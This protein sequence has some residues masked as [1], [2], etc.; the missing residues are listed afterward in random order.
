MFDSAYLLLK[1]F[2]QAD[3]IHGRKKL[4]KM[5]HLLSIAGSNFPFKYQYHHY[6]PY[7]AELQQEIDFMVSYGML[8]EIRSSYGY[9][10]QIT[11]RGKEFMNQLNCQYKEN[12]NQDLVASLNLQSSQFLEMVSTYA[13]LLDSNY[14]SEGAKKKALELKPHLA[15]CIDEA[16]KYYHQMMNF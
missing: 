12:I 4:Q 14:D 1:L 2:N 3:L 13:F 15:G 11:D 6:G 10:Y 8:D 9:T 5:V 16:M 7:S